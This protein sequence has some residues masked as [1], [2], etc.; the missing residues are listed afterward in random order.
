[1][2]RLFAS[3][4]RAKAMGAVDPSQY[5]VPAIAYS[6]YPVRRCLIRREP[7]EINE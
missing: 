7:P 1:M 3:S 5:R 6:D 4:R 2:A